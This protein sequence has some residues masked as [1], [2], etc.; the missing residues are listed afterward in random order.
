MFDGQSGYLDHALASH[1]LTPQVT[2]IT[3]WHIN[4]DEPVAL[5]Y[6]VEF[7]T[8][9][10]VNTFYAGDPFRSSDHDPVVVGINL[11]QPFDVD[12]LLQSGLRR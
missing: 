1:A 11:I 6:N 3:E 9:N 10:Q 7:K 12:G 8:A 2:G 4:A 5:D